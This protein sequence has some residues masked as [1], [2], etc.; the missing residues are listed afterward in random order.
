MVLL[1]AVVLGLLIAWQARPYG[2]YLALCEALGV[3]FSGVAALAYAG[4]VAVLV[5]WEH[6]QKGTVCMLFLFA[7]VWVAFRTPA[8]SFAGGYAVE[9]GR[10]VDTVGAM[11]AAFWA[12]MMFVS[13]VSVLFL[14]TGELLEKIETFVP[15]LYQAASIAVGVCKFIGFFATGDGVDS[16]ETIVR[17][18]A[19]V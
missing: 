18:T 7:A 11:L 17:L 16:L 19:G 14:T 8:R 3:T 4:N 6:P 12:T 5:P 15:A 13:V 1:I 10:H 9:F 2:L